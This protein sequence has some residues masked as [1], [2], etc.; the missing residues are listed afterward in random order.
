MDLLT[1]VDGGL[2]IMIWDLK[3]KIGQINDPYFVEILPNVGMRCTGASVR[4]GNSC[5]LLR[6][7]K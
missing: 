5:S 7:F 4:F 3:G 2:K 6:I 1:Q